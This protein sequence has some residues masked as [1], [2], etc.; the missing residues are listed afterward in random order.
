LAVILWETNGS[1]WCLPSLQESQNERAEEKHGIQILLRTNFNTLYVG[2]PNRACLCWHVL[3]YW[4]KQ[5]LGDSSWLN[6]S[7]ILQL[8]E[9]KSIHSFIEDEVAEKD[10]GQLDLKECSRMLAT[11]PKAGTS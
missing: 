7:N 2:W 5:T 1:W 11:W 6:G 8:S 10:T 4:A 3:L 9:E